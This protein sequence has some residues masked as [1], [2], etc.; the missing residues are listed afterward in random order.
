MTYTRLNTICRRLHI[1]RLLFSRGIAKRA[2][3]LSS[4][5]Y[6]EKKHVTTLFLRADLSSLFAKS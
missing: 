3:S 2:F 5:V 4:E 6:A 1:V